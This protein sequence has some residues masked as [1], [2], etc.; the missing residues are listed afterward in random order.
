MNWKRAAGSPKWP[1]ARRLR[2][3]ANHRGAPDAAVGRGASSTRE[4]Q[5]ARDRRGLLQR[6]ASSGESLRRAIE[7]NSAL[8]P[9]GAERLLG[10]NRLIL[11][12]GE[13]WP[14]TPAIGSI[15]ILGYPQ[16]V[17]HAAADHPRRT[18]ITACDRVSRKT[19]D[20]GD[21][22][23]HPARSG[24]HS[25]G[26]AARWDCSPATPRARLPTPA[27]DPDAAALDSFA[28]FN[29]T[30]TD[31][32][33]CPA[34]PLRGLSA[35]RPRHRGGTSDDDDARRRDDRD[36]GRVGTDGRARTN[37]HSPFCSAA[38][39]AARRPTNGLD[40][41]AALQASQP[42]CQ[43]PATELD[44]R[45]RRVAVTLLVGALVVVVVAAMALGAFIASGGPQF[46]DRIWRRWQPSA[47]VRARAPACYRTLCKPKVGL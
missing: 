19:P 39:R 29:G 8:V 38:D 4:D 43:F 35:R 6:H 2:P 10:T 46:T 32:H 42:I 28:G 7:A 21:S 27:S 34:E 33:G 14:A 40:R 12:P 11:R 25:L 17:A 44:R 20:D 16:G 41:V 9:L 1:S 26:G 18:G 3:L 15:R 22:C 36:Q 31:C 37:R 24:L 5:G 13:A 30:R 47:Q 45:R 23:R